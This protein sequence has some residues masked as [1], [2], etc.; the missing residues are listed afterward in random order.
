M[1][2]NFFS[3]R[4]VAVRAHRADGL[5][6]LGS[7]VAV[8]THG[9]LTANHVIDEALEDGLEVRI[10]PTDVTES[11]AP[12]FATATVIWRDRRWDLALLTTRDPRWKPPTSP[13]PTLVELGSDFEINCQVVGLAN[14]DEQSDSEGRLLRQTTQATGTLLTAAQARPP[15]HPS[16]EL[17]PRWCPLDISTDTPRQQA[18][19]TG[20]SGAGVTLADGRLAGV[21][22]EAGSSPLNRRL[23]VVPLAAALTHSDGFSAALA[24]VVGTA[25]MI[26]A[27]N[28]P[29][30]RDHLMTDAL[31]ARGAPG[32]VG[33]CTDLAV[34]GVKHAGDATEDEPFYQY[35]GRDLDTS[36][37]RLLE[38][39]AVAD[40][41]DARMVLVTGS[42]A[43]GKSRSA[44]EAA[45]TVLADRMFLHPVTDGRHLEKIASW[46]DEL[47]DALVWLDNVEI[48]AHPSMANT[49]RR[50]LDA[51]AVVVG[52]IRTRELHRLAGDG[53]LE[54]PTGRALNDPTLVTQ[55]F[56]RREWTAAECE[57]AA[58]V[59]VTDAARRAIAAGT[60]LS[61]W[62]VAGPL[63]LQKVYNACRD[64]DYPQRCAITRAV[65]DW[66]R[67][68]QTRP[69]SQAV[70]AALLSYDDS[71]YLPESYRQGYTAEEI[72]DAVTKM[73]EPVIGTAR[74]GNSVLLIDTRTGTVAAHD[75]VRDHDL[76]R[77]PI[78]A[79]MWEA[80]VAAAT[81][82]D[83][84]HAMGLAAYAMQENETAI[85]V[86][87]QL[88]AAGDT[89][90]MFN[91]GVLLHETG[92]NHNGTQ[93]SRTPNVNEPLDTTAVDDLFGQDEQSDDDSA[94]QN[95]VTLLRQAVA[96]TPPDSPDRASRL[97]SLGIALQARF[98][99]TGSP[100]D[101]DEAVD[102]ARRVV[103]ATPPDSPDLAARWNNLGTALQVRFGRTADPADL[104]DAVQAARNA[105]TTTRPG[106]LDRAVFLSNLGH[107][108]RAVYR[109]T[110]DLAVIGET[111]RT[112]RQAVAASPDSDPNKAVFLSNLAD[113]LQEFSGRTGDRAALEEAVRVGRDAVAATPPGHPTRAACLN[114][115]GNALRARYRWTGLRTDLD[116]AVEIAQQV[117]AT[118][119]EDDA[120]W[121]TFLSNLAGALQDLF[122][123]NDKL[124]SLND[125][126]RQGRRAATATPPDYPIRAARLNNLGNSLRLRYT[127]TG[128]PTDLDEAVE[129]GR[130]VVAA[131]PAG[132]PN[133]ATFL[134]NLGHTLLTRF[135][136]TGEQADLNESITLLEEASDVAEALP[137]DRL[138]AVST[139]AELAVPSQPARAA[140][141]FE[142]AVRL[143]PE[144]APRQLQR[145]DQ[146]SALRGYAGL[147]A[148]AAALALE[149]PAIP[150][151]ERP[152]VALQLLE[153][154]RAVLQAQALQLRS[155]VTDLAY[156]RPDLANRY[157]KI[158][159]L[160]DRTSETT[161]NIAT[162]AAE[163]TDP[164]PAPVGIHLARQRLAREF[165]AV[166]AQIRAVDGFEYFALPPPT[167]E[168]IAQAEEG[169]VVVFNVSQYRSDAL[170]LTSNGITCLPLPGLS[171]SSVI[172][173]VAR[174]QRALRDSRDGPPLKDRLNARRQLGRTLEW[175][176][177]NAAAPALEALGYHR[178]PPVDQAWPRV[179]WAPGGLLGLL[180]IQA[181]GYHTQPLDPE[182]RT[183]IDRVV[184]SITSTV[185]A[186]RHARRHRNH[187]GATLHQALIVA[188][189]TTPGIAGHLPFVAEEVAKVLA[190]LPDS[191]ALVE[192]EIPTDIGTTISGT[193][194]PTKANV[195]NLL[196]NC[197]IAHFAC[198]AVSS[199]LDPSQ[200][201]L[202]LHDH[203]TEP[204][205]VSTLA[206]LHLEHVQLAYLSGCETAQISDGMLVDEA[207]HLTSAF[208]LAGYPHVIGT[209]WAIDDRTAARIAEMFYAA[210]TGTTGSASHDTTHAAYALHQAV[211]A[212]RDTDPNGLL[213]WTAYLHAGT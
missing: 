36:L 96:A 102:L 182:A 125:A 119:R 152:G 10:V 85:T 80:A 197:S 191:I 130:H 122:E 77:R 18:G 164:R 90:A 204:L 48:Y 93:Q 157:T 26:E 22:I 196:P 45:R 174:F 30:F 106:Q 147:A 184:P 179:W 38:T 12:D 2:N 153:A 185:A 201:L 138:R 141:L 135:E 4:L 180:P 192:S 88:V 25:V 15:I 65:L 84:L 1:T 28:A 171:R 74:H 177:D 79:A 11:S 99:R 193:S 150:I 97:N 118:S 194:L 187:T 5:W 27:H 195:L 32:R 35:A 110:G 117:V 143:L 210:L 155:D 59:T 24:R 183:V 212:F 103:A 134:N 71:P 9:I 107:G 72:A 121:A 41:S 154:G 17:P 176:W 3:D 53:K 202:L 33:D 100:F 55:V 50:L 57:R 146:Y 14:T 181:A 151:G 82:P 23:Y 54:F 49:L 98:G 40:S 115:L 91:I 199:P 63:L 209:L 200:S 81:A 34:F 137:A 207:I 7:G 131:T 6:D 92:N 8:A 111:I 198:H 132:D 52:T 112:A 124:D 175:L 162:V 58:T 123:R 73:S 161:I 167:Q 56:V 208:Q 75:Y 114:N 83:D 29:R 140:S 142:R 173:H 168:L 127:Q 37:R 128:S 108:L 13:S 31:T 109:R 64:D 159:D 87:A 46:A 186:L 101:L 20:M 178:P 205:T 86:M 139:A 16:R 190:Q 163:D 136:R 160:L 51:G 213:G 60:S 68:G 19:W 78:P 166:L 113:A 47:R 76:R 104:D 21:V 206:P 126:I 165:G 66:F 70:I 42:A 67:T 43:A 169:P 170:L 95:A 156:Q 62:A 144:V 145:A 158:R 148:D 133:S 203:V 116:D 69:A 39:A 105:V 44:A 129:I 61:E 188:M 94:L 149:N 189:P 172:E 211:R 120:N 89:N